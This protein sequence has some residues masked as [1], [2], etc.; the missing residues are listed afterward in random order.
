MLFLWATAPKLREAIKVMEAWGFEYKTHACWDKETMGMGYWFRGQHELLLVGTQG[1]MSPPEQ[2][3]RVSS[4]FREKRS[5]HSKKPVCVYDAIESM[6]P[7][8]KRFE[9]YQRTKRSGWD[10]GGLEA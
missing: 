6:F 1:D 3:A 5:K 7:N 4:M 2:S 8:A 9:M 10:G